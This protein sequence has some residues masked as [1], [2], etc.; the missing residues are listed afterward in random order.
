MSDENTQSVFE[1]INNLREVLDNLQTPFSISTLESN[2]RF[3]Y[4]N[5]LM[6]DLLGI[7]RKDFEEHEY[8]ATDFYEEQD[9]K[10]LRSLD[11]NKVKIGDIKLLKYKL[12]S[13][14]GRVLYLH[15]ISKV[16]AYNGKLYFQS[17]YYDKTIEHNQELKLHEQEN[18]ISQS[19][20]V[21]VKAASSLMCGLIQFNNLEDLIPMYANSYAAHA[22]GFRSSREFL[23]N[24]NNSLNNFFTSDK[25]KIL[26]ESIIKTHTQEEHN[27]F[28]NFELSFLNNKNT[29]TWL[30][31][32]VNETQDVSGNTIYQFLFLD[33]TNIKQT[34]QKLKFANDKFKISCELAKVYLAEYNYFDSKLSILNGN[35][36]I[37]QVNDRNECTLNFEKID[38]DYLK[39]IKKFF[40]NAMNQVEDYGVVLYKYKGEL[41][42][43]TELQYQIIKDEYKNPICAIF[44]GKD[45][46]QV[47]KAKR[48]FDN[49]IKLR[50]VLTSNSLASF[51]IDLDEREVISKSGPLFESCQTSI[52]SFV[53]LN[54]FFGGLIHPDDKE[55]ILNAV[56]DLKTSDFIQKDVTRSIEARILV[57]HKT[58]HYAL[59][60][61]SI[62]VNPYDHHVHI[63]VII[64]DIDKKKKEEIE[65][66]E[67]ANKDSLTELNNRSSFEIFAKSHINLL[68]NEKGKCAFFIID[69]DDFK[70]VN[71]IH[72][73]IQGD[74][75]LRKIANVL[76]EEIKPPHIVARLGGDEFVALFINVVNEEG[77]LKEANRICEKV[78]QIS[79][80]NYNITCSIGICISNHYLRKYDDLY[81]H[82][83][84]ALYKAKRD[85]KNKVVLYEENMED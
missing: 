40:Y 83:D 34:E 3:V 84:K 81:L 71:D 53:S 16:V 64:N 8:R 24:K 85:G 69:I 77:V 20:E 22:F 48:Y 27:P 70:N 65:I 68:L 54:N 7:T 45:A 79:F 72:G 52:N 14:S 10:N 59:F 26:K 9:L 17:V 46:T 57:A 56:N 63:F 33:T 42:K 76:K 29:L 61:L 78:K 80:Q 51:E 62:I 75:L 11:G 36:V 49:E 82:A 41:E 25:I 18:L 60:R 5:D 2:P 66:F 55:L 12:N 35:F 30:V 32:Y 6:L 38:E 37:L 31:G 47:V 44:V 28:D 23:N 50:K 58:Y 15:D 74:I 73:H 13:K 39:D 21:F 67:K 19:Q 1:E 4:V 43:W